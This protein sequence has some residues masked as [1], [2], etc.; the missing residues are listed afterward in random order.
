MAAANLF[1]RLM[2]IHGSPLISAAISH[3][4]GAKVARRRIKCQSVENRVAK[5]MP[6]GYFS[7]PIWRDSLCVWLANEADINLG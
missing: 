7:V 3:L 4:Y 1:S 2:A 6:G 5:N